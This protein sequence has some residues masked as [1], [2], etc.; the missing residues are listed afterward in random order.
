MDQLNFFKYNL[1]DT[2]INF[3]FDAPPKIGYKTQNFVIENVYCKEINNYCNYK[4]GAL[5]LDVG[6]NF[7]FLSLV[8]CI[9]LPLY[10]VISFEV[11]PSI[12]TSLEKSKSDNL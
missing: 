9:G 12:L 1:E 4:E 6:L 7:G 11:H 5:V 10:Q 2:K 8:W 3:Y